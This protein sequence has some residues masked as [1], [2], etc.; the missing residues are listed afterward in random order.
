MLLYVIVGVFIVG[1]V[2]AHDDDIFMDSLCPKHPFL[3]HTRACLA[4]FAT[5]TTTTTAQS[6]TINNPATTTL[7]SRIH[8]YTVQYIIISTTTP[9]RV[10]RAGQIADWVKAVI[11][12]VSAIF[13][14][15]SSY[16]AYLK[17]KRRQPIGLALRLGLSCAQRTL[18]VQPD[19]ELTA[20]ETSTSDNVESSS[21]VPSSAVALP[22]QIEEVV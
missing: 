10:Q 13:A 14:A 2:H 20:I 15:Y 19:I 7:P 5:S 18:P 21:S 17:L 8:N 22:A 6:T 3:G 9:S 1:M 16:V 12:V 4:Y 11:S